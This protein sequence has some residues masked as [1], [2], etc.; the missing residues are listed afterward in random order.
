MI[1]S[2]RTISF[3]KYGVEIVDPA[4][5]PEEKELRLVALTSIEFGRIDGEEELAALDRAQAAMP[6]G[7]SPTGLLIT[8]HQVAQAILS[9]NGAPVA[10]PFLGW[11]RWP[12]DTRDLVRAAAIRM[13]SIAPKK[14]EDFL[15]A[16]FGE[17][18]TSPALG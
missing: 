15:A 5:G 14:M 7:R 16:E 1:I 6:A 13:N 12:S 3:V 4:A 10:R 2:K 9:V 18:P 8:E 17:S 11:K